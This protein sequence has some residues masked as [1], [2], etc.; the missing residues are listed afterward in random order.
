MSC[1]VVALEASSIP[2]TGSCFTTFSF[3]AN[4]QY[5]LCSTD[6]YQSKYTDSFVYIINHVYDS[7]AL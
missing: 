5:R 2:I 4:T 6:V 7:L 3:R 1:Y